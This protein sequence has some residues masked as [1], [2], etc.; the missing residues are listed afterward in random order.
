MGT[1][2][3]SVVLVVASA[4]SF[5]ADLHSPLMV[6]VTVFFCDVLYEIWT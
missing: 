4:L 5:T 2:Q 6:I 3:K 1:E